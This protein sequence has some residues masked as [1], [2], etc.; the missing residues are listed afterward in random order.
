MCDRVHKGGILSSDFLSY[1][2]ALTPL[3]SFLIYCFFRKKK[4]EKQKDYL[5][6]ESPVEKPRGMMEDVSLQILIKI[7]KEYIFPLN[8]EKE[9]CESL[10][11]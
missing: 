7:A 2:K 3:I 6:P 11:R 5:Q 9:Q 1:F 10:A 4:E 8:D